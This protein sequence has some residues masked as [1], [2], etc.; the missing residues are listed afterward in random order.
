MQ[1]KEAGALANESE[2]AAVGKTVIAKT[3]PVACD[4]MNAC[5][6]RWRLTTG[7]RPLQIH[8]RHPPVWEHARCRWSGLFET[9]A[10]HQL[11]RRWS[12]TPMPQRGNDLG[13][14]RWV[15]VGEPQIHRRTLGGVAPDAM[16]SPN[17]FANYIMTAIRLL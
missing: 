15:F 4:S 16:T 5:S 12:V 2:L 17:A 3:S 11:P 6:A 10:F 9:A 1:L 8:H 7:S 14:R 13:I